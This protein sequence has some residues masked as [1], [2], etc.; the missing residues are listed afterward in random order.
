MEI[1]EKLP[2]FLTVG[3]LVIIF[4]CLKRHARCARL[5]SWAVGWALVF[6]HFLA[7]LLEPDRGH[8]SSLLLAIDS[9]AL[10][11]AAV[12][13][14]VSVSSV[15]E[16][17]AKRTTLLLVLGVPA[18]FYSALFSTASFSTGSQARW[19][20]VLSLIACFGGAT[21]FFFRLHRKFSLYLAALTFVC[22]SVGAWAIRA[23][24]GG[25]YVEGA[26]ALLGIGFGLPGVFICR[27]YWRRSF[28]I[29]TISCG[30][31]GWGAL[32]PIRL[33]VERFAPN[34]IVPG[35]LWDVP[36][37]FVAFGMILAIVE[38]KSLSIT[39]MQRR[40]E[41]LNHQLERFAS[42][43]SR[44]LNGAKPE[45]VCPEIAA[46]ITEVSSFAA[47]VVQLEDADGQL[48]VVAS[49]GSRI[50]LGKLQATD[51]TLDRIQS[52]CSGRLRIGHNSFLLAREATEGSEIVEREKIDQEGQESGTLCRNSAAILI[53]LCSGIGTYLGCIRVLTRGPVLGL[54]ALE[55]ARVEMVAADLAV[56]VQ[57]KTLHRQL[58]WSEKLAALGQLLAGVAHE[59][60]NPL[61][62]I[63]GYGELIGDTVASPQARDQLTRL[64]GETRRM[65]RI[66]DNLLRFAR[67][68]A[69]DTHIVQLSPLVHEVLALCE[70]Y[71]R[72]RKVHVDLDIAP[73]LPSLAVHEDEIKQILLNLFKNSSDALEGFAGSKRISIRAYQS[74]TLAVIEVED[75]GPGFSNLNRALEPFFTTKPAGEGTG[76]G[77]SVC[78]G[79]VKHRGGA[80]RIENLSPLGARVT[81]ELPIA[82]AV[83]QSL[84]AAVANA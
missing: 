59:L 13:F 28:G 78:C 37:L 23:A 81:V 56:A 66:I 77:L 40:A 57:L 74:G 49:S 70:Y 24:L 18:L 10:Q 22:S 2:T 8:V 83:P 46:A 69:R 73:G 16:D 53:P 27:N 60:N 52:A 30:F 9:V 25:S 32:F 67:R 65:K 20:Y 64:V 6:T 47:A 41:S 54:D 45:A 55:L 42:I 34:L 19:V 14:L 7:Q 44:L 68:G 71:T 17:S 33:W 82:E 43:T 35:A 75:S 63:L 21:I 48:S 36:E 84:L 15:V 72:K 80:L 31:L 58:V 1:L 76:L 26:T 38:D 3:A 39:G 62:V 51:W 11:A 50:A 12:A 61:T 79:I 5:T 29:L 4:A